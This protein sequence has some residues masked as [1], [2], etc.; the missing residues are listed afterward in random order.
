MHFPFITV[1]AALAHAT[2]GLAA[3]LPVSYE[4]RDLVA[5]TERKDN[6]KKVAHGIAKSIPDGALNVPVKSN[7]LSVVQKAVVAAKH[8]PPAA[9]GHHHNIPKYPGPAHPAPVQKK[10][11]SYFQPTPKQAPK[12]SPILEKAT[13]FRNHHRRDLD[14]DIEARDLEIDELD[15]VS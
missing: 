7:L 8:G 9:G 14:L 11:T 4:T 13:A 10:T 12:K 2:Q 1:F 3:P 5:R 15:W 6:W